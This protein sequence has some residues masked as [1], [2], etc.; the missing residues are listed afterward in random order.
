MTQLSVEQLE[1]LQSMK[2]QLLAQKKRKSQKKQIGDDSTTTN[3]THATSKGDLATATSSAAAV[4][5]LLPCTSATTTS[6]G[7]AAYA[8]NEGKKINEKRMEKSLFEMFVM[9]RQRTG[10]SLPPVYGN[11]NGNNN[12]SPNSSNNNSLMLPYLVTSLSSI[13]T[14]N[15]GNAT[16]DT[17]MTNMNPARLNYK[18]LALN[19]INEL[20]NSSSG[21]GGANSNQHHHLF[22]LN[23]SNSNNNNGAGVQA[24]SIND[25]LNLLCPVSLHKMIAF[26]RFDHDCKCKNQF[27]PCVTDLAFDMLIRLMPVEQLLAVVVI[28]TRQAAALTAPTNHIQHIVHQLYAQANRYRSQACKE[29]VKD[30]YRYLYYDVRACM[31]DSNHTQSLLVTRHNVAPGM[32]LVRLYIYIY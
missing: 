19:L 12:S 11:N 21:G 8:S 27:V 7:V 30:D 18:L 16:A 1:F 10:I 22:M 9:S 23:N 25:N 2:Q 5:T 24:S 3:R 14:S 17:L 31:S 32:V 15:G 26:G 13:M 6:T 20:N 29:S 4:P 28:D